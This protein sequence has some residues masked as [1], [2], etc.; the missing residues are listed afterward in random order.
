MV[1]AYIK[2]TNSF[3][4]LIYDDHYY[5]AKNKLD[6]TEDRPWYTACYRSIDYNSSLIAIN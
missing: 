5:M 1:I 6:H 3:E 2:R 4:T